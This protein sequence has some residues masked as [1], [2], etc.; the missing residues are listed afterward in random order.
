MQLVLLFICMGIFLISACGQEADIYDETVSSDSSTVEMNGPDQTTIA[1][2]KEYLESSDDGLWEDMKEHSLEYRYL[3]Y[4]CEEQDLEPEIYSPF[5]VCSF[6]DTIYVT[7]ASTKQVVAL[8]SE[9]SV[10]WKAGSP[11]EGPGHFGQMTTLAAS[12]RYVAVLNRSL[13][14]IEFFNRDG[15]FSHNIQFAEPQDITALDDTTFLVAS[16]FEPGGDIHIVDSDSGIVRSFGEVAINLYEGL[17]RVDLMRICAGGNDR[18]AL[19]NRYEGL[20]AIYDIDS[21]ECIYRGNREYPATPSPPRAFTT[22][23]GEERMVMFPIGG[24]AFRGPEGML[25]VV[26]CNYMDDGSFIS[27]PDYLDFAPITAVDRYDWDGNYLDSYCLPDSSINYVTLL[28]DGGLVARNFA[29]GIL[30]KMERI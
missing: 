17:F 15:S 19:F 7:D 25:N 3:G 20:L 18:V 14:R 24:N 1:E 27:D 11:G 2:W 26:V 22:E 8:D 9:G 10:L 23:S 21:E 4:F 13:R 28:P 12:R 16:S 29:E 6:A 30:C 5:A